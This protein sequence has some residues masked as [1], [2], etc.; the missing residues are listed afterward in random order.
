[1]HTADFFY[2]KN[3]INASMHHCL[4]AADRANDRTGV[5]GG[6]RRVP[7]GERHRALGGGAGGGDGGRALRLRQWRRG[8]RSERRG[9][10]DA[11]L[12]AAARRAAAEALVARW[13]AARDRLQGTRRGARRRARRRRLGRAS[14]DAAARQHGAQL[15]RR[16]LRAAQH[17]RSDPRRQRQVARRPPARL[18]SAN[19]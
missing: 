5:S 14:P 17:R 11:A 2:V 9:R 4:G 6:V 15:A 1:M 18:L 10:L 7:Q 12:G 3:I 19:H 8:G 13:T 16:A